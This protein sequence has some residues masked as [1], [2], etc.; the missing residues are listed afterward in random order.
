M[1]LK[2]LVYEATVT[3]KD[4]IAITR[5]NLPQVSQQMVDIRVNTC[6]S[7][8]STESEQVSVEANVRQ[9]RG[10]H[11]HGDIIPQLLTGGEAL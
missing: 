11:I 9:R 5:A 1:E 8:T 10:L 7:V 6:P 4:A 3:Q 2:S